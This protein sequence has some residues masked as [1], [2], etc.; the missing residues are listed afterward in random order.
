MQL[1]K[2]HPFFLAAEE[3]PAVRHRLDREAGQ[4]IAGRAVGIR[5]RK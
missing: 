1:K 3:H 5:C 2:L 4:D